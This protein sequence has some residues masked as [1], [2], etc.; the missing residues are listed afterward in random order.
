MPLT[1]R[2]FLLAVLAAPVAASLAASP[3]P[4]C[5]SLVERI[6]ASLDRRAL[7]G[8]TSRLIWLSRDGLRRV[9][10]ELGAYDGYA[11]TH[12]AGVRVVARP[13]LHRD[14]YWITP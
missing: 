2:Q 6:L 7:F 8:Q 1:R 10:S 4:A 3:L 5:S 13:E 14:E 9:S 11:V 12:L